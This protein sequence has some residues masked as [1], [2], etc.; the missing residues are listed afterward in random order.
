MDGVFGEL[1]I[2]IVAFMTSLY[3]GW[4]I[5]T[6]KLADE[7]GT[8]APIFSKKIVGTLTP[9]QLWIFFIK[10]VCPIVIGLVLLS[11]IGII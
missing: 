2:V 4:V 7:I 6:K 5:D 8:G 3:T 9:A 11:T 10:Y 1:F